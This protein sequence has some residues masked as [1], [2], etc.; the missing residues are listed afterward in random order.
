MK[1]IFLDCGKEIFGK[2]YGK[3]FSLNFL[4]IYL[5]DMLC[6]WK[7]IVF[8]GYGV[9]LDFKVVEIERDYD[10]LYIYDIIIG[11]YIGRYM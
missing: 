6:I 5:I 7:I 8:E 1:L 11:D 9:S 10:M 2:F 3:I 4:F